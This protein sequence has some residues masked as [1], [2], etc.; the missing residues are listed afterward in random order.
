MIEDELAGAHVERTSRQHL[1]VAP[2]AFTREDLADIL[3]LASIACGDRPC[4]SPFLKTT[5][6]PQ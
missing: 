2:S 4:S 3:E 1:E 6:L 5:A